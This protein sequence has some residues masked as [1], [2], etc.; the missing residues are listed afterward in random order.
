M[1]LVRE[2]ERGPISS[3]ALRHTCAYTHTVAG[4]RLDGEQIFG[5]GYIFLGSGQRL[6]DEQM[7]LEGQ[8]R[9]QREMREIRGKNNIEASPSTHF[10][11]V[12]L[13]NTRLRHTHEYLFQSLFE[14]LNTAQ[15]QC[16][17]TGLP[18][19]NSVLAVEAIQVVCG[20]IF[21]HPQII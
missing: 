18:A 6:K 9:E 10:N 4:A 11:T 7:S 5:N 12:L 20:L 1:L 3:H 16:V 8:G 2:T 15:A 17:C 14:E 19:V 21:Q 13:T